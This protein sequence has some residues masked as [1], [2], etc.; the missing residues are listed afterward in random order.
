MLNLTRRGVDLGVRVERRT[1]NGQPA[2]LF[3]L[4]RPPDGRRPWSPSPDGR[5]TEV[6]TVVNPVKLAAL[7]LTDPIE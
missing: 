7:E 3:A 1:I 4:G 5:V 6:D 2:V